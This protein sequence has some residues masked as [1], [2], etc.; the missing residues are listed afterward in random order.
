MILYSCTKTTDLGIA[1]IHRS[2]TYE[3]QQAILIVDRKEFE[4]LDLLK[5]VED[6]IFTEVI[7]ADFFVARKYKNKSITTIEKQIVLEFD[8]SF[9]ESGFKVSDFDE[10]YLQTDWSYVGFTIY[11]SLLEIPYFWFETM[12]NR[13]IGIRTEGYPI[14]KLKETS[15]TYA[16]VAKK[17][18]AV[19]PDAKFATPI[20]LD[21]S[22]KSKEFY[23]YKEYLIWNPDEIQKQLKSNY[24]ESVLKVWSI[25]HKINDDSVFLLRASA[26]WASLHDKKTELGLYADLQRSRLKN[27]YTD[28]IALDYYVSPETKL[29]VKPHP[30]LHF[31]DE[32]MKMYYGANTVNMGSCPMEFLAAHF[33]F[34]K[35]MFKSI[36]GYQSASE[37]TCK[38]ITNDMNFLSRN[39]WQSYY[40]YNRMYTGLIFA[41]AIGENIAEIFTTDSNYEQVMNLNQRLV[42]IDKDITKIDAKTKMNKKSKSFVFLNIT[43][44]VKQEFWEN[45]LNDLTSD[46][47]VAILNSTE[48]MCFYTKKM[49]KLREYFVPIR[50]EKVRLRDDSID[51]CVDETLWIFSKNRNVLQAARDFTTEKD[52]P[53][54]GVKVLIE[55]QPVSYVVNCFKEGK[56]QLDSAQAFT[57]TKE[58]Q[59]RVD[60][61]FKG[62]E[63]IV[64]K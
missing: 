3:Q 62:L 10:I 34:E 13:A 61:L 15:P 25:S 45:I 64:E 27:I 37:N 46:S 32:M 63:I 53:R 21:I 7:F 44:H 39:Y 41:K 57:I 9:A 24:V 55:K 35:V 20:L 60:A 19:S 17:H 54:L 43:K 14:K 2:T 18:L 30:K 40:N 48:D 28:L 26:A 6:G 42:K 29:Y 59:E 31:T 12:E 22:E 8:K 56:R 51:P 36:L 23:S 4:T 58:L 49:H 52:L 47:V 38:A 5:L 33:H 16:G 1:L 11:L 50:I